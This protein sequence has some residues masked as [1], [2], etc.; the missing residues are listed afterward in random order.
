MKVT[1]T[2][3][4]RVEKDYGIVYVRSHP[5]LIPY[6]IGTLCPQL[7]SAQLLVLTTGL[8]KAFGKGF[9][10][11]L[12]SREQDIAVT[13]ELLKKGKAVFNSLWDYLK[14]LDI[15][16]VEH[17]SKLIT[18]E[19]P[20]CVFNSPD[21]LGAKTTYV[22]TVTREGGLA[23]KIEVFGTGHGADVTVA[24]K[25][26][27]EFVSTA[28]DPKLVFA[29]LKIRVV[30]ASSYVG[31]Q[32]EED[33]IKVEL[34]E[35]V[36]RDA[37]GLRSV[38]VAEWREFTAGA[39]LIESFDLS[40]DKSSDNAK[41]SRSYTMKGSFESKIGLKIYGLETSVAVKCTTDH[42]ISVNFELPPRV[43]HEL[44]KPSSISGFFFRAHTG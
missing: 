2:P 13:N 28:G 40:G 36:V 8:S 27:A 39:Q 18:K 33:F 43:K 3:M 10:L 20:L 12:D 17:D 37:N 1:I 32:L 42:N 11:D 44:W 5:E 6:V 21:S 9:S 38:S 23:W 29:P 19:V 35:T 16:V 26:A 7:P 31:D 30:K 25:S 14:H 15:K 34:A 22:E 24:V 41:Y 4:D